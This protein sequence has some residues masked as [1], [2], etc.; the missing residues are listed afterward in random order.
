MLYWDYCFSNA[1]LKKSFDVHVVVPSY[2]AA[3]CVAQMTHRQ[4]AH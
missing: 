2:Q 4:V 3:Y 1:T